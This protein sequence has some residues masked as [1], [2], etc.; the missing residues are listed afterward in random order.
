MYPLPLPPPGPALPAIRHLVSLADEAHAVVC[1]HA[2]QELLRF[3]VRVAQDK[4][5]QLERGVLDVD[6]CL[7]G[8]SRGGAVVGQ[9]GGVRHHTAHEC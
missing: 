6:E 1:A 3:S 2:R 4:R 7:P 5:I 9:G 8:G